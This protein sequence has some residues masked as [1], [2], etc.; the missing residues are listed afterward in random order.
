VERTSSEVFWKFIATRTE[1]VKARRIPE[2][3]N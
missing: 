3:L 1:A 2:S